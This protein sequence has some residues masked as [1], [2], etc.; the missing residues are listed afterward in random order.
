MTDSKHL[1]QGYTGFL[2]FQNR[3]T[4]KT[5]SKKD[6]QI[7]IT[8]YLR[9]IICTFAAILALTWVPDTFSLFIK[10]CTLINHLKAI[11]ARLETKKS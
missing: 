7:F 4:L 3:S 1:D 9:L 8:V 5:L 10:S 2:L 11:T 6:R